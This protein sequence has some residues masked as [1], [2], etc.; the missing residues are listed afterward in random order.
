MV[1]KVPTN[2][3]L[4]WCLQL[5]L[6]Q[7]QLS[8]VSCLPNKWVAGHGTLARQELTMMRFEGHKWK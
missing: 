6:L 4:G 1:S 5:Q 7:L 8:D 3:D 2:R